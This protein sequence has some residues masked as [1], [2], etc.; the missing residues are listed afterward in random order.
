VVQRAGKKKGQKLQPQGCMNVHAALVCWAVVCCVEAGQPSFVLR[1]DSGYA[2]LYTTLTKGRHADRKN[3]GAVQFTK[4]SHI[5]VCV[6]LYGSPDANAAKTRLLLTIGIS[7]VS[8]GD[9]IRDVKLKSFAHDT[10]DRIGK[11]LDSCQTP[12]VVCC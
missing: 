8:R 11:L 3:L 5:K 2:T 7:T 1:D 9:E 6:E 12:W 4:D 10:S